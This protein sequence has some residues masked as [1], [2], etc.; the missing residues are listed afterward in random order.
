MAVSDLVPREE[1]VDALGRSDGRSRH[2]AP[3]PI[4]RHPGRIHD[5]LGADLRARP[6]GSILDDCARNP[7]VV[8][9][10]L[11]DFDIVRDEGPCGGRVLHDREDESSIVGPRVVVD[12]GSCQIRPRETRLA[13]RGGLAPKPDS[14]WESPG[15]KQVVEEEPEP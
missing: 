3:Q 5:G 10:E 13:F 8:S 7:V 1:D 12:A 11:R 9:N 15:R 4:E 14:S 2:R 6:A